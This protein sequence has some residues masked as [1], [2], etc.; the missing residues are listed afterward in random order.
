MKANGHRKSKNSTNWGVLVIKAQSKIQQSRK[1]TTSLPAFFSPKKN[2]FLNNLPPRYK[3]SEEISKIRREMTRPRLGNFEV[4][5]LAR[6]HGRKHIHEREFERVAGH[7]GVDKT[8]A[9]G[10]V[11]DNSEG[12]VSRDKSRRS[13]REGEGIFVRSF[14]PRRRGVECRGLGNERVTERERKRG[15]WG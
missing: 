13:L 2:S 1:R 8:T 9:R 11:G 4:I 7:A 5:N 6:A 12:P 15:G 10:A 3:P 14:A